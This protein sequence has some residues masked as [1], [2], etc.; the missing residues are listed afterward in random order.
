[1]L[2]KWMLVL[3]TSFVFAM[4]VAAQMAFVEGVDYQ[5]I[6]PAVPTSDP[7]KVVVTEIFWYGCPHCFRF[8][9][10]VEKW[11]ESIP[12]GVVFEQVPSAIN[13]AWT[14]HAR[15]YYAFKMMGVQ[16]QLHKQLFNAIHV[17]RQ[18]L[19]SLDS[20][21]EFVAEQGLD[22]KEFRKQYASFPVETLVRKGKQKELH[23]GLE[24]VPTVI[25]NGKYRTSGVMAGN[26]SRLL[27]IIDFLVANELKG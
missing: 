8:E 13:A 17:Q 15:A 22:E 26:F 6:E 18:R 3:L 25:V 12:D 24:G 5:L 19:N 14:V 4:P 21:A 1:M 7:A 20:I 23:Y 27:Q 10:F 9:P 11:A 16:E 2:K